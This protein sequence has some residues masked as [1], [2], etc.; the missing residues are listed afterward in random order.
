MATGSFL[1]REEDPLQIGVYQVE[2]VHGKPHKVRTGE[3][4]MRRP[5]A[6]ILA[7]PHCGGLL[8]FRVKT[9][10]YSASLGLLIAKE[11]NKI[12]MSST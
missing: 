5:D 12:G 10:W 6:G 3:Q 1:N 2:D 9:Y 11:I 8:A 4:S 7:E